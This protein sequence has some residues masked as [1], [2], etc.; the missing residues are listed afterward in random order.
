MKIAII[1]AGISGVTTAYALAHDGH[2]VTVFEKNSAIAEGASFANAGVL[3]TSLAL[4]LSHPAWPRK[5][6][7]AYLRTSEK[8]A[9][10]FGTQWNDL[11]WLWRWRNTPDPARFLA[12]THAASALIAYSM[13]QLNEIIGKNTLQIEQSQGSLVLFDTEKDYIG[14]STKADALAE[15][16]VPT[17]HLTPEEVWKLEPGLNRESPLHSGVAM[18]QDKVANC[19]Q[20]AQLIKEK[21]Q[22]AGVKLQFGAHITRISNHGQPS[23][24]IAQNHDSVPFDKI[25]ICAGNGASELITTPS[26]KNALNSIQSYSLSV[27]IKEQLHAPQAAVFD[28]ATQLTISRIGNRIRVWGGHEMGRSAKVNANVV[29]N[30]Y[31]VLQQRFPGSS[32]LQ[33]GTQIYKSSLLLSHDGLPLIGTSPLENVLLN[34]GH[35]PNHWAMACGSAKVIADQVAHRKPAVETLAFS[36][37][38]F[39]K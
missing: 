4:P 32:N 5:K 3:S 39:L 15:L 34:T 37:N 36:P 25:V 9:L 13:E 19:R 21:L 33:N 30:F 8:L 38:R 27:A 23:L 35:G 24:Q 2:A 28:H 6:W 26:L 20:F 17:K 22:N 12:N 11:Q 18:P 7:F 29:R 31:H 1:G 16:G 14:F 10:R